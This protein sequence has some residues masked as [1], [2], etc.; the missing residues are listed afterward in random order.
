VLQAFFE[1]EDVV[2]QTVVDAVVDILGDVLGL[3]LENVGVSSQA[4]V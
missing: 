1:T 2:V 4:I 3:S